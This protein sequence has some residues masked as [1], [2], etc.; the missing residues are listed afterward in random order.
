LAT[1]SSAEGF[2]SSRRAPLLILPLVDLRKLTCGKRESK[3][4]K[5]GKICPESGKIQVAWEHA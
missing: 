3:T 4:R 5:T 1:T 2:P